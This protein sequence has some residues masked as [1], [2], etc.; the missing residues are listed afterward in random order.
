MISHTVRAYFR[1]PLEQPRTSP[2]SPA[3]V[4]RRSRAFRS[5]QHRHQDPQ[6]EIQLPEI[7]RRGRRPEAEGTCKGE[8]AYLG[9]N[10]RSSTKITQRRG[11]DVQHGL[12]NVAAVYPGCLSVRLVDMI[13]K[14]CMTRLQS[15]ATDV[16]IVEEGQAVAHSQGAHTGQSIPR[17]YS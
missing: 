13:Y 9:D 5:L 12:S 4:R 8:F 14:I 15:E 1:R 7:A 11:I 6:I 17:R 16:R 2:Q 3:S 10:R